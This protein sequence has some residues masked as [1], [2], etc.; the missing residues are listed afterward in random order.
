M[1]I[2]FVIPV[3]KVEQYIEQCVDSVLNQTY[4]DI[5]VVLVDDGSPDNCPKICD[6][7]AIK[8]NR[9]KVVHKPNGG[10]SDARNA[11][12]SVAT[13]DHVIFMDSDDFWTSNNHLEQLIEIVKTN[14]DCDFVGFNCSYFYPNTDSYVQWVPY[15][16]DIEKPSSGNDAMSALVRS[17]TFP[18]SACMKIIKREFLINNKLFFEKGILAEDIP[19]FINVL[20]KCKK[21]MFTNQYIY[22]YRQNVSGSITNSG[23][24]RS[25]NNL[26]TILKSEVEKINDR[27]FNSIAKEALYSFLAYEY[28][29]LLG[30]LINI[31]NPSLK[32]KELQNYKWLLN[33][34]LN[35]K[36]KKVS[37]IYRFL[38]LRMTE[39]ALRIYNKKRSSKH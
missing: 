19:W 12:L 35:P 14:P 16:E 17:G 37:Y 32:R 33:Y 39:F 23:G 4:K 2:S 31:Q 30:T 15:F 20:E 1:K 13:G 24:E 3:Y 38:G 10:L 6:E 7:Y 28:C 26:F 25:F 29:I 18:M 27:K 34:T 21:C 22:A 8:D 9:I 36:V 5:E 11:G